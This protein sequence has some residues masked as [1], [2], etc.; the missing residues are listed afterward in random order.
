MLCGT[1]SDCTGNQMVVKFVSW[2][3]LQGSCRR[4]RQDDYPEFYACRKA[5]FFE[6]IRICSLSIDKARPICLDGRRALM[7]DEKY[8]G[9]DKRFVT[10]VID[11]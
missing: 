3:T 1:A 6:R 10:C 4:H 8:P 9:R 11:G 7:I 2:G 5:A